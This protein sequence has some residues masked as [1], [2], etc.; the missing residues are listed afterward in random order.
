[1]FANLCGEVNAVTLSQEKT[2]LYALRGKPAAVVGEFRRSAVLVPLDECGGLWTSAYGGLWWIHAFTD[3]AALARF[4][5]QRS[6]RAGAD[7]EF[8]SVLGAR[9]LDVVIPAVG[10][11]T[12]VALDVGSETPFFLPP[13]AGVVP[14]G[15][16]VDT[17]EG[18]AS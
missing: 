10:E 12:G 17:G 4:A 6:E 16:V 14:D 7:W 18:V 2:A 9:L 3:E 8:V 11:P 15:V 13:V 5:A 1:M